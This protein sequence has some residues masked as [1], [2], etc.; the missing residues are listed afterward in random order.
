M[1]ND[2]ARSAGS[3]VI[4]LKVV[5]KLRNN[6]QHQLLPCTRVYTAAFSLSIWYIYIHLFSFSL[7]RR[8]KRIDIYTKILISRP[9]KPVSF[10]FDIYTLYSRVR[11]RESLSHFSNTHLYMQ[12]DHT[13]YI[14]GARTRQLCVVL[15][16][17]IG[18]TYIHYNTL[19][20]RV[21]GSI[22][23]HINSSRSQPLDQ[24]HVAQMTAGLWYIEREREKRKRRGCVY[25]IY[26]RMQELHNMG[27]AL[28][29]WVV[30]DNETGAYGESERRKDGKR[31]SPS[32]RA[33][34]RL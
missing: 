23:K 16:L 29:G 19:C 3:A 30:I 27:K 24:W 32:H 11:Q 21:L 12:S 33:R 34:R 7:S 20:S 8:K 1:C 13:I 18:Y 26:T 15:P 25:T 6:A 31:Y 14:T 5:G 28:W 22:Y 9:T 10:H 17:I 2:F 4:S